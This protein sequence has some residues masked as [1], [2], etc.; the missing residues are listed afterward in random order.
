MNWAHYITLIIFG[1]LDTWKGIRIAVNFE[2]SLRGPYDERLDAAHT[3]LMLS[4][5]R[6]GATSTRNLSTVA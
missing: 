2:M 1:K 6:L 5:M 4:Q 3:I